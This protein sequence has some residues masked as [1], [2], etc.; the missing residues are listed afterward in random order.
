MQ[1]VAAHEPI[2]LLLQSRVA[3]GV[4][5]TVSGVLQDLFL[6]LVSLCLVR[7]LAVSC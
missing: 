3:R 5:V 4:C 7:A 1:V 2:F 6:L